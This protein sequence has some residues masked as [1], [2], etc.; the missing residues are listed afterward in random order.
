MAKKMKKTVTLALTACMLSSIAGNTNPAS[1]VSAA[2]NPEREELGMKISRQIASEGMV[3]LRNENQVLP[4]K[5][6]DSVAV[7]GRGAAVT[8][9]GGTGSGNVN[10]KR[11]VSFYEGMEE[12]FPQY[13]IN[14]DARIQELYSY[15]AP[16]DTNA[17]TDYLTREIDE[18]EVKA[19]AAR[20]NKAIFVITRTGSENADRVLSSDNENS[21]KAQYNL[22]DA[23]LKT[24][25]MICK[26]FD[27]VVVIYNT[28][29]TTDI[30]AVVDAQVDGILAS[31]L[32]GS[33]SG[34]ALVDVLTGTVNPSGKLN[35]TWAYHFED[36]Y[37]SNNF[38]N[39]YHGEQTTEVS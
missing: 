18:S 3:L 28:S 32:P 16:E 9:F 31:W 17:A 1:A 22:Y 19:A 30:S 15:E 36:H 8:C 25:E 4:L 35:D 24:L 11:N 5:E 33:E 29:S 27:Q 2:S 34:Y 7:F 6:G 39:W 20:N 26:H 12:L 21:M 10:N 14:L 13:G 23:E 37:S 38:A